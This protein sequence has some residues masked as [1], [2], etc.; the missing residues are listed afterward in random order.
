MFHLFH[1][2][3][4]PYLQE[5]MCSMCVASD[6]IC[7]TKVGQAVE[8]TFKSVEGL[9]FLPTIEKEDSTLLDD[10]K[11]VSFPTPNPH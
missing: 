8:A 4:G 6:T 10:E 7:P 9:G 5:A 1:G 2:N 11:L 3:W